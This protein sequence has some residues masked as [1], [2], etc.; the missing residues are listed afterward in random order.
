VHH[1][2]D[3]AEVAAGDPSGR[4]PGRGAPF[5]V[6][7]IADGEV[8]GGVQVPFTAPALL[9]MVG[10]SCGYAAYDSV[11]PTAYTAPFRYSGTLHHVSV[12]VSGE[13]LTDP[14]AEMVRIMSQQ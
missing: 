5:D 14:A 8:I 9:S 11:D 2:D 12:D 1:D 6:V 10:F 7:L 3:L 4:G 13:L